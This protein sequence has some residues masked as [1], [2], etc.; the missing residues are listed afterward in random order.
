MLSHTTKLLAKCKRRW[1]KDGIVETE[2]RTVW[3]LDLPARNQS[4]MDREKP[5]VQRC[6]PPIAAL[7]LGAVAGP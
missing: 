7:N 5:F 6:A 1:T 4:D 2:K 3:K